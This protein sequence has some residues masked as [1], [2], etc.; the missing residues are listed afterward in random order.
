MC[1]PANYGKNTDTHSE[2]L[3]LI[4]FPQQQC[5]CKCTSMLHNMYNACLISFSSCCYLTDTLQDKRVPPLCNIRCIKKAIL[6]LKIVI[7]NVITCKCFRGTCWLLHQG[8]ST[9]L[10][11]HGGSRFLCNVT[12][13]YHTTYCKIS[14]DGCLQSRSCQR[15][16][17]L[18]TGVHQITA[19]CCK[20][21]A[22]FTNVASQTGFHPQS[23]S[24]ME[25][26][27]NGFF[28]Y[29]NEMLLYLGSSTIS[30]AMGLL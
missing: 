12:K 4:A 5:L 17:S 30:M 26:K 19:I 23:H 18:C 20:H 28:R 24:R 29:V 13:I 6:C 27:C 22:N 14:G 8:R 2:Y 15:Q 25:S 3:I 16:Q 10:V 11:T 21:T 1:V 9:H 7:C